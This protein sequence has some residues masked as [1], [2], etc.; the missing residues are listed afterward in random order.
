MT[1]STSP[2]K[3][4]NSPQATELLLA[5][6]ER[7]LPIAPLTP[8]QRRRTVK[9][10]VQVAVSY[11]VTGLPP[12]AAG[13]DR[14]LQILLEHWNIENLALGTGR[15]LQRRHLSDHNQWRFPGDGRVA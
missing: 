9:G 2:L 3:D 10:L 1:G 12:T 14:L 6:D 7:V 15:H 5:L 13:A 11:A 4:S 8:L